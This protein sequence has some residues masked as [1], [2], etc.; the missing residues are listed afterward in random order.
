MTKS[1]KKLNPCQTVVV[2]FQME[3]S[4]AIYRVMSEESFEEQLCLNLPETAMRE[5]Q[6][7]EALKL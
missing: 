3:C 1:A 2:N 4:R 6:N 5:A 7:S